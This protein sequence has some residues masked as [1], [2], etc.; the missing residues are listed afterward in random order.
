MKS[1]LGRLVP[2]RDPLRLDEEAAG[3]PPEAFKAGREF[4]LSIPTTTAAF[5]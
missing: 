5:T 1:C 2:R 3:G 4:A